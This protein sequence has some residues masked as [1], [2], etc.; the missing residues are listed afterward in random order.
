MNTES[1]VWK[2]AID[3]AKRW[4]DWPEGTRCTSFRAQLSK[5]EGAEFW[6]HRPFPNAADRLQACLQVFGTGHTIP[7]GGDV[8]ATALDG[9]FVWHLVKLT[10]L[11]S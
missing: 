1:V 5:G 11:A 7:P 2:Y 6:L 8:L 10:A 4:Y 3:S 9:P